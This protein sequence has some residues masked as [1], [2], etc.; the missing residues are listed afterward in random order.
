MV[1]CPY[2]L[3]AEFHEME[4]SQK[5]CVFNIFI[6]KFYLL[7]RH[8][9]EVFIAKFHKKIIFLGRETEQNKF[10]INS[11]FGKKSVFCILI[12]HCLSMINSYQ[13]FLSIF[14]KEHTYFT[15]LNMSD[16]VWSL[17]EQR[18]TNTVL[19]RVVCPNFGHPALT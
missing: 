5:Y 4:F 12:V 2:L 17:K 8:F 7:F 3:F 6:N 1:I 18:I 15:F 13:I 9:M 16:V 19:A 11:I 10:F 14:L